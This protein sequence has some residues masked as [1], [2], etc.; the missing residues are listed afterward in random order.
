MQDIAFVVLWRALLTLQ[1]QGPI[2]RAIPPCLRWRGATQMQR[3]LKRYESFMRWETPPSSI[4]DVKAETSGPTRR[5]KKAI[6]R[7]VT[8]C[9]CV[10]AAN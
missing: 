9:V 8:V 3:P 7:G 4:S 10:D 5:G 1:Q 2:K 6:V